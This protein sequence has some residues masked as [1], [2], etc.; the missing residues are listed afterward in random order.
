MLPN[1]IPAVRFADFGAVT[2]RTFYARAHRAFGRYD[3]RDW[4]RSPEVFPQ[5]THHGHLGVVGSARHLHKETQGELSQEFRVER[6][7][8]SKAF[9]V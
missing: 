9:E 4:A 1:T 5:R 6:S 2:L 3:R 8:S 7:S